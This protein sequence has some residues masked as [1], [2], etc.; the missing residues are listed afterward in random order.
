[1]SLLIGDFYQFFC[2]SCALCVSLLIDDFFYYGIYIVGG[3]LFACL[4]LNAAS[5]TDS[6]HQ[7]QHPRSVFILTK[8]ANVGTVATVSFSDPGKYDKTTNI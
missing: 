1:M 4:S 3:V 8:C 6:R 2:W 5:G 7:S